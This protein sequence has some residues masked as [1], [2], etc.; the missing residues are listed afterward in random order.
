MDNNDVGYNPKTLVILNEQDVLE[1][2]NSNQVATSAEY[3]N[4]SVYIENFV[5]KYNN[6]NIGKSSFE[7]A[8]WSEVC[9]DLVKEAIPE[10][11]QNPIYFITKIMAADQSHSDLQVEKETTASIVYLYRDS[12]PGCQ[13]SICH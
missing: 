4:S 2:L 5:D 12:K 7:A 8:A 3:P 10:T 11:D 1:S 13:I 9:G 6:A